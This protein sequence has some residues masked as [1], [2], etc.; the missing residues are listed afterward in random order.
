MD[1]PTAG[2]VRLNGQ[3]LSTLAV[4]QLAQFRRRHVGFVF[5]AFNLLPT[6]TVAE[7]V[8]LPL[9]LDGAADRAARARAAALLEQVGLSDR[10]EHLPAQ[11]SGGEMQR[12]AVAR[13]VAA[14]PDLL[15][16]DEPT[17]NLDTANGQRVMQLLADLNRQFQV[18]ILLATHSAEAARFAR[19]KMHLRDGRVEHAVEHD[20]LSTTV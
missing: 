7:N 11:L 5:Q 20:G 8:A 14:Q 1:R 4:E 19:R 15:L 3:D 2:T 18:T 12:V 10:A 17:G 13:A 6:L 16:A 9:T